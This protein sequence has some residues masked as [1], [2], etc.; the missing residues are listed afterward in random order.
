MGIA[1]AIAMTMMR[2]YKNADEQIFDRSYRIRC[3]TGQVRTDRFTYGGIVLGGISG[4]AAGISGAGPILS[5]IHGASMGAGL[6]VFAHVL[7]KKCCGKKKSK[8]DKKIEPESAVAT[9]KKD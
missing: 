9:E 5:L 2:T 7:T 3:N 6:A 1:F 8:D 4:M